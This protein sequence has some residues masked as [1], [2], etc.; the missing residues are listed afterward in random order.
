MTQQKTQRAHVDGYGIL[1][2]E[3]N[4]KNNTFD[5]FGEQ[6]TPSQ[7]GCYEMWAVRLIDEPKAK[8]VTKYRLEPATR[9]KGY[10]YQFTVE[11]MDSRG[12]IRTSHPT[13][14]ATS[15]AKACEIIEKRYPRQFDYQLM[16][17]TDPR[18]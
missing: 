14:R 7:W 17:S 8:P 12:T 1:E 13:I 4:A 18:F 5:V 6:Y 2:G 3:Y 11:T 16:N 15:V 9:A 10:D